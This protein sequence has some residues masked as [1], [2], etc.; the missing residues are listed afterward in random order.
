MSKL[1]KISSNV[2]MQIKSIENRGF[3]ISIKGRFRSD[4]SEKEIVERIQKF[5]ETIELD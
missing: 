2:D 3:E 5:W 4:E 1:I